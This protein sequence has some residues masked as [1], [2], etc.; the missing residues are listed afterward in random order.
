MDGMV[1]STLRRNFIIGGWNENKKV[2]RN[3]LQNKERCHVQ[4]KSARQALPEIV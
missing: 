1:G 4:S 3:K 2:T